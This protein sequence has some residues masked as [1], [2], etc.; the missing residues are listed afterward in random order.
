MKFT[1]SRIALLD[2]MKITLPAVAART[3]KPILANIKAV[4]SGDTLTLTAQD[5]E[6][7]IRYEVRGVK[8]LRT[9]EAI[10]AA[11][12]LGEIVRETDDVEITVDANQGGARITVGT[13]K[14]STTGYPV[15][16]FPDLPEFDTGAD[17]HEVSAGDLRT[18]IRRTTFAADKKDSTRF[19]LGS[20]LWE[21]DGKTARAV[22]T[23]SK[24]LAVAEKGA[25][26]HGES[27]DKASHLI[28]PKALKLLEL[29]LTDDGEMVRVMLRP[30]EAMFR[31][32][33]ATIYTRLL[34]GRFPPYKD[35]IKQTTKLADKKITMPAQALL[36]R[37]RQAKIM[38]DDEACRVEFA[39]SPGKLVLEA[40]GAELGASHVEMAL[41]EYDGP[42]AMIAFDPD[43]LAEYLR[44]VVAENAGANV[45]MEMSDG[46][47]PAM[48]G[49]EGWKYMVMP[50]AG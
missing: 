42:P 50:L 24:R 10:L 1:C 14:F 28:P 8:V 19:A 33:R 39:F 12:K 49:V 18:M 43:Y 36:N 37:V 5:M 11:Q 46:G 6:I 17:Y 34:E 41:P 27:K 21:A 48:L 29:N 13:S 31:T 4:A 15:A 9:G 2:A 47:K 32:E 23:D 22:A 40:N 16:E 26:V 3:T 38:T 44:V 30:N 35:I 45:V 20:V 7:G 25:T